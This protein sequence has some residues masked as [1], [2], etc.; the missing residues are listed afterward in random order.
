MADDPFDTRKS[1]Y[2][3]EG[4]ARRWGRFASGLRHS[5]PRRRQAMMFLA[6]WLLFLVMIVAILV[7]VYG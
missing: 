5:G 4:Q 2:S 3:S 1:L 6:C 7:V